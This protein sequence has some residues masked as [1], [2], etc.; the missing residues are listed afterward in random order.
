LF[1]EPWRQRLAFRQTRRQRVVPVVIPNDTALIIAI[2][3]DRLVRLTS[4]TSVR[5]TPTVP[6]RR[7]GRF[8]C[9]HGSEHRRE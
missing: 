4:S 7:D 9:E 6:L 8:R 3:D 5:M 2:E 1:R